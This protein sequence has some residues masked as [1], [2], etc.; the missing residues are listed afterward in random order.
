MIRLDLAE[1]DGAAG[2]V[3]RARHRQ[4]QF[5]VGHLAGRFTPNLADCLNNVAKSMNVRLAQIA[6]AGVDRK[7]AVGP[8]D[9]A[10]GYELVD[11]FRT[12]ESHFGN[13]DQDRTG[14]VFVELSDLDVFG[15][16]PSLLVRTR[17][18]PTQTGLD[19]RARARNVAGA[20]RATTASSLPGRVWLVDDVV[21]TGATLF[22]AA[23]ALR[24]VGAGAV[25]GVCVARTPSER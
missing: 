20:F 22:E 13:G 25:V 24:R 12:A 6:A 4:A 5:D 1:Q 11:F 17:D 19:R 23:R 9:V 21:T 7:A 16:D 3:T 18:T 15:A 2:G 10:V 8:L 14:E